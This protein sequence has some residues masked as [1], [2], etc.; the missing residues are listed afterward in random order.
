MAYPPSSV[1]PQDPWQRAV[2]SRPGLGTYGNRLASIARRP[3]AARPQSRLPGYP[4][5]LQ[6]ISDADLETGVRGRVKAMTD[7]VVAE[8]TRSINADVAARSQGIK[9][10]SDEIAQ[11]LA[12]YQPTVRDI[13]QR[14]QQA[15][16]SVGAASANRIQGAGADLSNE[17]AAKMRAINAPETQIQQDAGGLAVAGA[18]GG[19]AGYLGDSAELSALISRGAG[20]EEVAS[21]EPGWARMAGLKAVGQIESDAQRDLAD[22]IGEITS[23]VPATVAELLE[24]AKLQEL[25]KGKQRRGIYES[26]RDFN[27]TRRKYNETLRENRR[28]RRAADLLTGAEIA[29][30]ERDSQRRLGARLA[31]ITA[32]S[33]KAKADRAAALTRAR[34]AHAAALERAK[35]S[36]N[37][38]AARAA[39]ERKWKADQDRIQRQWEAKQKTLDRAAAMA[40][41]K[42]RQKP[43]G[44]TSSLVP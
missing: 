28:I 27:E 14:A 44:T 12:S 4:S 19:N 6:P 21:R 24:A 10:Y 33:D 20:A 22:R 17:L 3:W 43:T 2:R 41:T 26:N 29:A 9:R 32:Q 1:T 31:T 13:Y 30:K 15:Q 7:P 11:S 36:T 38:A 5:W 42:A 37:A 25:E 18:G 8:I 34:E 35:V 39:A 16:A 23:Q 40:R